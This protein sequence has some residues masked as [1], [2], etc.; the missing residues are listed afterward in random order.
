MCFCLADHFFETCD[1]GGEDA[2]ADR[3]EPIVA[4]ARIAIVGGGGCGLGGLIDKAMVHQ[5]FEIVVE[6]AGAELV[7]ALR[8]TGDL[9]HD[10]VAVKVFGCEGEENVEL[11]WG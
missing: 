4:A 11:G 1:F 8:L 9:L 10:A 3:G 2:A 6:R 5:F 7:F